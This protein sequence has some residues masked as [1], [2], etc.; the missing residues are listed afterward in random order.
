MRALAI[1]LS[2]LSLFSCTRSDKPSS[3]SI[4]AVDFPSYDAARALCGDSVTLLLPPGTEIHSYEPTP[5]DM[6]AISNADAIILIGGESEEWVYSIL[7]SMEGEKNVFALMEHVDTLDEELK[8]GMEGEEEEDAEKDEHVWT[9]PVNEMRII[10][11]LSLFL[12]RI[13]P[14]E[15]DDIERRADD[16]ISQ[17]ADID[18]EIRSVVSSSRLN[19]LIFASRFPF[20]YFTEE[21]GLEYYAAF[22]GCAEETEPSART[23]AFLIDKARE[24][25]VNYILR[26]EFSSSAIPSLIA[27]EA[28]C[29]VLEFH[30]VHNLASDDFM[31]GE[32]YVTLMRRNIDV[33]REALK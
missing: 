32:T 9:S 8:E 24:L 2:V 17:L 3:V 30:S 28:G 4:V 26:T 13:M 7:G 1:L 27:S 33:L 21:Y 29:S 14:D 10:S 15:K 18:R 16:Y 23:I 19:T 22:P 5:K 6:I 11:S 25:G 20:R 12:S 31:K